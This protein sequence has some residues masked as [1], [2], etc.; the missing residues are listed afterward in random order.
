MPRI[1]SLLVSATLIAAGA[2]AA[3]INTTLTMNNAPVTIGVS[4]SVSGTATLSN[5]GSGQF[6]TT[7]S[8]TSGVGSDGNVTAPFT[9]TLTG[10]AGTITGSL[11]IPLTLLTG[12]VTNATGSATVT[13]GTYGGGVTGGSFAALAGTVSGGLATSNLALS[14]NGSGTVVTSGSG[15]GGGTGGSTAPVITAVQD[16]GSYTSNLAQGCMFVVKGSNLSASG[17]TAFNFPLP[18]Q[19]TGSDK[20]QITFTPTAGG[21]G[22]Q[23]YLI[24]TYNQGGVNQLAAILPSTLAVGNYN[25]T[26]TASG[27][28]SAPFQTTVAAIKPELFTGD[29]SGSG[30]ALVQNVV[31]ASQYDVNRFT[32]G[33]VGGTTISPAKPGE[34]LVA[35]GTGFGGV[36]GGDNVAS[37]GVDLTK[38]ANAQ[39]I[40]GG[41]TIPALYVGRVA[42]LAG[43]D[44]VNVTLPANV[45]TGCTVSFQVSSNGKLSAPT[46]IAIAPSSSATACVQSGYT[47]QQLQDFDNGKTITAGGFTLSQLQQTVPSFG[48]VKLNSIGGGFTQITGFQLGSAGNFNISSSTSGSC[49]VTHFTGSSSQV[50]GGIVNG[51]DAGTVTFKGPNISGLTVTQ[52]PASKAYNLSLGT[53]GISIP[54]QTNVTIGPG[55]YSIS[56][57]GGKD[58]GTFN[59]SLTLATPL[60]ISG[61][62]PASVNRS[63]NLTL[64]WT[65]GGSSDPVQI[66]GYSGTSTGTGATATIDATEFICTTTAGPG[67]FT[68]PSSILSQLPASNNTGNSTGFLEVTSGPVP[69]AFAPSL[70]A[71]G[72]VTATF[73][74]LIGTGALVSYQ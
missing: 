45:P 31:S 42:S 52:D 1:F 63:S 24:Y 15:G 26:V 33:S 60:T 12:S 65:G 44:Q 50:G 46:F 13:G 10:G 39:V 70:T 22:T 35:Y 58:V 2:Q 9:V 28:T 53:E 62:L 25:V 55:A 20:A 14:I 37:P 69:T 19:S 74:A 17:Y 73:A 30:L 40:V 4:L 57:A 36:T 68:V 32:T 23:A 3:T 34:T 51:L 67:T 72:S 16:A 18:T 27:A 38:S 5:I 59:A 71:G 49:T 47:T 8:L 61:G 6:A 64:N 66:M 56:G 43:L 54:G 7:I 41:M 21:N 11:K 48:T 29:A